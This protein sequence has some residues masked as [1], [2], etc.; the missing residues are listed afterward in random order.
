MTPT[1]AIFSEITGE[2]YNA[3]I[4]RAFKACAHFSVVIRTDFPLDSR[5]AA[6]M[7][8]LQPN[9]VLTLPTRRT[10]SGEIRSAHRS[11]LNVYATR[12]RR[13]RPVLKQVGSLGGWLS[14]GHPED[15][16]FYLPDRSLAMVSVSHE[17]MAWFLDPS[18]ISPDLDG[19]EWTEM[20]L[21]PEGF[22][23]PFREHSCSKGGSIVG[24]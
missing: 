10:P 18:L 16:C 15:L 13:I 6:L 5:M 23:N 3:L 24:L 4:D 2:G 12:P 22:A 14:P 1:I 7:D 19:L 8:D 11:V 21:K 20:D 17:T 9:L